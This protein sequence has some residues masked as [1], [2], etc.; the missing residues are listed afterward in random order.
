MHIKI[1]SNME[2]SPGSD[3]SPKNTN[4]NEQVD[5]NAKQVDEEEKKQVN[6]QPSDI[7]VGISENKDNPG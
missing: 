7:S 2:N 3:D 4:E 5:E 1:A 6:S